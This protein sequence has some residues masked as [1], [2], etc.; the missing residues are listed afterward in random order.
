MNE[1]Q[2]KQP[3]KKKKAL[4]I[5]LIVFLVLLCLLCVLVLTVTVMFHRY[6]SLMQYESVDE[7]IPSLTEEEISAILD[8]LYGDE[9]VNSENEMPE[10]SR[11]ELDNSMDQIV[12]NVSSEESE[13]APSAP[14]QS[15][16]EPSDVPPEVP[17]EKV[18]NVLV[19][20]HDKEADG[21][22]RS[23]VMILV[24]I[25][26]ETGKIALTSMLR[27]TYLTIPGYPNNRLNAAYA[28]GGVSLLQKTIKQN[29]DIDIDR[30]ITIDF[31]AF[32]TIIDILGGIELELTEQDCKNVFA[33]Q[34]KPAGKYLLT[35]EQ[36]LH[37]A[38]WRKGS[39][40]FD[41]TSRQRTVMLTVIRRMLA[42]SL[43][44]L[45]S[46]MEQTLP[47]VSTD[48]TEAD[49]YS[50]LFNVVDLAKYEFS[51][52]RIPY[53]GTWEYATIDGRDVITV[54]LAENRRLFYESTMD[55]TER[56]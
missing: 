32:T 9:S 30:Y 51:S 5:L 6:Y 10:D 21:H 24:S 7:S 38:R 14:A 42:M 31:Q 37:Y 2:Q 44:E 53:P 13:E 1:E 50:I 12:G 28:F 33:G 40:D 18:S 54:D 34:N 52:A 16:E 36:A 15:S 45:T 3:T 41:R 47:L 48:L 43:S 39:D 22:S 26:E 55:E 4:R 17:H 49:C 46:V 56:G 8:K 29:F 11:V 27:D 23:D 35:A 19:I 25:N 20:G